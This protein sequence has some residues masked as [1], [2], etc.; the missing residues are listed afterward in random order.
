MYYTCCQKT[1]IQIFV[2]IVDHAYYKMV[3]NQW[4]ETDDELEGSNFS[5]P[6]RPCLMSPQQLETESKILIIL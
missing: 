6:K 1:S 3:D 4:S 5:R 2:Q